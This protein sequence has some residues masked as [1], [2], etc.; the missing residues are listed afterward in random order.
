MKNKKA[1]LEIVGLVFIV[2]IVSLAML[3]YL[4]ND[5]GKEDKRL[6]KTYAENELGASYASVFTKISVCGT[7]MSA[8]MEDCA[9]SKQ[10]LCDGGLD[11]C[12]T[13]NKTIIDLLS[14][15][16]DRWD[17]SYGFTIRWTD[18]PKIEGYPKN[19]TNIGENQYY[20]DKEKWVYARRNCTEETT[21]NKGALGISPIPLG[22]TG[23]T[24]SVEIGICEQ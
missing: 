21:S 13:L 4:S 12:Q 20:F 2:I 7:E 24:L 14:T 15:T 1:Q 8:L 16:L 18:S 23:D 19:W 22:R 17:D 9:I 5:V 10:I 3:I 11:S 6:Y